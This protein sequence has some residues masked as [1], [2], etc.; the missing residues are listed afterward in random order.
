MKILIAYAGKTGGCASMAALLAECLPRHEITVADLAVTAPSP[1]DFDYVVLG[2][3]IR[4]G[5][6]YPAAR[7]Y[8]KQHEAA[9]AACPHTL[10]LC[11]AFAE[12]FENY[13]EMVFPASVLESA[14]DAMYFGGEL[15]PAKH[16]GLDRWLVKLIRNSILESEEDDAALP[17]LLPEH[18]RLLA[19]RLKQ[20]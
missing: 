13:L 10:F 20:K 17:G 18:V 7:Q 1:S 8:L 15:T 11:C 2:G 16:R 12:Q 19:E 4:M 9:L 6:L 5:K 14:E 3:A